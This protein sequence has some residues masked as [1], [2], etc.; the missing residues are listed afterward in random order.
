[1]MKHA[2]MVLGLVLGA[3]SLAFGQAMDTPFQVRFA[4][5]VKKKDVVRVTNSGANGSGIGGQI[6]ANVYAF[7]TDGP[8]IGCCACPLLPNAF[9]SIPIVADVLGSP[10][11]LPKQVVLKLMAS[12]GG[13]Q[14]CEPGTVG[15][16]NNALVLGLLAWK[17][18]DP[19][20]PATLSAGELS[21]LNQQCLVL[22]PTPSI[23]A[24]CVAA[25]P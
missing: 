15:I 4:A 2:V 8:M 21:T 9:A 20:A 10:K 17:G 3:S 13:A 18:E 22:H 24:S 6:C 12:K 23:C 16:G 14:G 5:N 11:P 7:S 1:M 19:F 25:M